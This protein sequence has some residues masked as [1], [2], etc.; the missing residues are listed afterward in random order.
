MRKEGE[1][2]LYEEE[3][4][5]EGE[6]VG[7]LLSS[8]GGRGEEGERKLYEEDETKKRGKG[9]E[10]K[11]R[12]TRR[13]YTCGG[14]KKMGNRRERRI[15]KRKR[16]K[17]EKKRKVTEKGRGTRGVYNWGGRKKRGNRRERRIEK[18][19]RRKI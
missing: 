17:L 6:Q 10:V 7:F 3:D 4:E 2:K 8:K 14:R 16:G 5:E 11:G 9:A 15:K 18:R 13:V 1:R 12:E 19:K